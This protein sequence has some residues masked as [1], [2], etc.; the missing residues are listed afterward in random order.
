MV[1]RP[2]GRLRDGPARAGRGQLLHREPRG[3]AGGRPEACGTS[4]R[5]RASRPRPSRAPATPTTGSSGP[6]AMLASRRWPSSAIWTPCSPRE[7]RGLSRGRAAP[8]RPRRAG[9]EGRPGGRGL[10][11]ARPRR[12]VPRRARRPPP[13]AHRGGLRRGGRL[14]RGRRDHPAVDRRQRRRAGLRV[15]PGAGRDHHPPQGHRKRERG[16]AGQGG[17]AGN[18]HAE[19]KNADLGSGPLGG[20]RAAAHRLRARGHRQR[21]HHLRRHREEHGARARRGARRHPLPDPGRRGSAGATAPRRGGASGGVGAR[22]AARALGR[23]EPRS[24]GAHCGERRAHGRVRARGPGRRTR[25]GGSTAHRRS[26]RREHHFLHGNRLHRRPR[27][28]RKG[29]HTVEEQIEVGPLVPKAEALAR[30]LAGR[31]GTGSG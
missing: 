5:S 22:D 24:A 14:S 13:A 21:G 25:S 26:Q 27:P 11:P 3:R 9:H 8:A 12:G 17:H 20:C 23:G 6:P 1:A 2:P 28:P 18:A 29:F 30:F 10:R 19:G 15:R 4:W 7:V 31:A 16:G